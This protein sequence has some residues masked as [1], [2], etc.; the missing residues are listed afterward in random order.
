MNIQDL[1]IATVDRMAADP[2]F[3][4]LVV[5]RDCG[6]EIVST[7]DLVFIE[8]ELARGLNAS[9]VAFRVPLTVGS[10]TFPAMPSVLCEFD[11][12][13]E[14]WFRRYGPGGV[15]TDWIEQVVG[16]FHFWRPLMSGN[17]AYPNKPVFSI[18]EENGIQIATIAFRA[19]CGIGTVA[20]RTAKP[21]GTIV[22]GSITLTCSTSGSTIYATTSGV[23]P[24]INPTYLVAGPVA[25]GAGQT[26][27]ARAFAPNLLA[28]EILKLVG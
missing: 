27:L 14:I 1:Q 24:T 21:A 7:A 13:V 17:V 25:V 23:M 5:V 10:P 4:G 26:L 28:S 9:G 20:E 22:A 3:E 8:N 2:V 16:F 11:M 15:L 19:S 12:T 18:R 6:D